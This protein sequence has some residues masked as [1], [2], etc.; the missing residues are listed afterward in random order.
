MLTDD[1]GGLDIPAQFDEGQWSGTLYPAAGELVGSMR[2]R[3]CGERPSVPIRDR[4]HKH[5]GM[6]RGLG[7]IRRFVVAN[8]LRMLVTTTFRHPP[9]IDGAALAMAN[10]IRR[11]RYAHGRFPFVWV[12]ERG[13]QRGRLHGHLLVPIGLWPHIKSGWKQ[14][15]V[16]RRIGG[17][18]LAELRAMA[19]YVGKSLEAPVLDGQSY[20]SAKGFQPEAF[21]IEAPSAGAI[22]A[23]AEARMGLPASNHQLSGVVLA[24]QWEA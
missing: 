1:L 21:R 2:L 10:L 8:G 4:C 16:D 11:C 13:A 9:T 3:S 23:E 6:L 5:E 24:A 12:L 22:L 17:D 7:R 14:G 19:S 20:R 18:G 15:H